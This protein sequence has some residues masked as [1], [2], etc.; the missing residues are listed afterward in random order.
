MMGRI[1]WSWLFFLALVGFAAGCSKQGQPPPAPA[2]EKA[3]ETTKPPPV[4]KKEIPMR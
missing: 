3:P 1:G 2:A 4:K